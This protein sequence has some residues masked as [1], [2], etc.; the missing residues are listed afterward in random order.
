MSGDGYTAGREYSYDLTNPENVRLLFPSLTEEAV[1]AFV[2]KVKKER[3]AMR[4]TVMVTHVDEKSNMILY[5]GGKAVGHDGSAFY[6]PKRPSRG[7]K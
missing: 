2:E 7:K 1:A 6:D 5:G 4:G 3:E